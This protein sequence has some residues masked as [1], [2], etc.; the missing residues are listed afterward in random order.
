MTRAVGFASVVAAMLCAGCAVI[1]PSESVTA[2]QTQVAQQ[3]TQLAE[4][5]ATEEPQTKATGTIQP[6]ST[7]DLATA[8]AVD[9]MGTRPAASQAAETPTETVRGG[10]GPLQSAPCELVAVTEVT[11]Y[12]RPD[13]AAA[14]FGSMSATYRAPVE[15]RRCS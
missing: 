9:A 8:T 2:L 7:Q 1:G 12:E 15:A 10:D 6:T 5:Q 14:V 11:V 13:L 4:L 3:A